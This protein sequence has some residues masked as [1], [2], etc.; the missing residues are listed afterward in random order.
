[1]IFC[2]L[3]VQHVVPQILAQLLDETAHRLP[4]FRVGVATVIFL[5]SAGLLSDRLQLLRQTC[6]LVS[7]VSQLIC[8]PRQLHARIFA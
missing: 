8:G 6:D 5:L 7:S 1:M 2:L 3:Q 4:P